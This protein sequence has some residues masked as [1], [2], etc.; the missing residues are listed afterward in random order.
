MP[1]RRRTSEEATDASGEDLISALPDAVLQVVLSFLPSDE[2]VRTCVLARRWRHLWK[3]TPALRIIQGVVMYWNAEEM[4]NFVNYLLLF[5]DRLPLDECEIS[6]TNPYGLANEEYSEIFRF[7][8]MWIRYA[9]S[10]CQAQVLKVCIRNVPVYLMCGNSTLMSQFLRRVELTGVNMWK[11]SLDFSSCPALEHLNLCSSAIYGPKISSQSVRRL[12]ITQCEFNVNTGSRICISAPCLVYLQLADVFGTAPLLERMP[13]LVT[14]FIRL[15]HG[16]F[17]TCTHEA[18]GDCDE[19]FPYGGSFNYRDSNDSVLL[20]GLSGTTSLELT[21]IDPDVF[22]FRKDLKQCPTFSMLKTLLLNEWCVAADFG[23]LVNFLQCTP[24]LEKLIIQLRLEK[25]PRENSMIE[26]YESYNPAVQLVLKH[27]KEVE[28]KCHKE[29]E[30]VCQIV[31]ILSTFGVLSD[32]I[33]IQVIQKAY[34]SGS[35]SFE[36]T[37]I[38]D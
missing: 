5:R 12:S 25:L 30:V 13:L 34:V 14:A 28:I 20:Q 21:T 18:Y 6:Y 29:D 17:G 4:N 1:K 15:G 35:F 23:A 10:L 8:N 33:D 37:E 3:S 36:Q 11:H 22:T 38:L 16:G 32:Q 24:I 27:L 31:K 2:T 26:T 7:A 19:C 9:V